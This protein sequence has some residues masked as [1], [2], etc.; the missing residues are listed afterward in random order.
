MTSTHSQEA[1]FRRLAGA[2]LVAETRADFLFFLF[3]TLRTVAPGVR[4]QPNWHMDAMAEY[5]AAAARGDITRLIINLPPRMLKS[6][7]VSVAWPAWLL[8]HNPTMRLMA[9]S[10]AQSLATKH[11]VDCRAVMQSRWYRRAFPETRLS[12]EQNEKDKFAT[13]QRGYRIATSVGGAA[14]GEGG[15]ILIV[16]DPINPLQA[17]QY[18]ARHAVN[19]WFDH[20]FATRLDDKRHGAIVL[21]MQRL[22][23]EDL[24]GYLLERDGWEHLNLPA[25]APERTV[26][27]L[28]HYRHV[29][30]AG[31]ALH[32][33]REDLKLLE[34]TKRELGNANFSAQYQQQ[35]LS[36]EGALVKPLWFPRFDLETF[37]GA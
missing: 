2:E 37:T 4:Y 22:H 13:T 27:A 23:K 7:M 3:R 26:I 15:H 30:A 31:T 24:S 6:T 14:T 29:R 34:R 8:G 10:Y 33:M 25:I 32:P 1:R 21:V 17:S 36:A 12:G 19:Q 11:S 18:A 28:G 16:D 35:P 9:A 5:L 20:T